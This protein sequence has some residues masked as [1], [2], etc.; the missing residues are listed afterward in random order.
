[1][2]VALLALALTQVASQPQAPQVPPRESVRDARPATAVTGIIRGRVVAD[3]TG[4]P[5]RGC[6]VMLLSVPN[7]IPIPG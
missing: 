7:E 2:I 4:E 1:M 5:V 6:R 3:D